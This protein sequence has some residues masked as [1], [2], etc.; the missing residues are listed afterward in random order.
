MTHYSIDFSN[1]A[2]FDALAQSISAKLKCDLSLISV[3]NV[4]A[5]VALGYSGDAA[6]LSGRS[7]ALRDTVCGQTIKAG[8]PLR[9]ANVQSDPSLSDLRAVQDMSIEAYLGVPLRVDGRGIVG[10]ICAISHAP[11][12]WRQSEEDYL[13]A[14]GDLVESKIERHLLRYE[15]KALSAALAENDA[16]LTMLAQMQGKAMTVHNAAGDLVFANCAMRTDLHLDTQEML[17]LPQVARS[18]VQCLPGVGDMDV[19]LPG[20]AQTAL[21]VHVSSHENGLTLAEWSRKPAE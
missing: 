14:V 8:H 12:I 17:S 19:A 9:V 11:R 15:Q 7:F 4:D 6:A 16:I 13:T 1:M 21:N 3:V 10:A 20:P 18:L 5:L 2:E